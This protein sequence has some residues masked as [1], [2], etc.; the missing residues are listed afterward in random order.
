MFV[1]L[2]LNCRNCDG[3]CCKCDFYDK[4]RVETPDSLVYPVCCPP[5]IDIGNKSFCRPL[6]A[7]AGKHF[8][9]NRAKEK[10]GYSLQKI[11]MIMAPLNSHN[12]YC[13]GLLHNHPNVLAQ[14]IFHKLYNVA[15]GCCVN[16]LKCISPIILSLCHT[17]GL[18]FSIFLCISV[19]ICVFL[20]APVMSYASLAAQAPLGFCFYDNIEH[21]FICFCVFLCVSVYLCIFVCFCVFSRV[22]LSY[23]M[24]L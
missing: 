9:E 20:G 22:P 21:M 15:C 12:H 7:L 18:Y 8:W 17:E 3:L 16:E 13:S 19:W 6:M 5:K 24:L 10:L 11:A 4:G 14:E 1:C 23:Q 2:C